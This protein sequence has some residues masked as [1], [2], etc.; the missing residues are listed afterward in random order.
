MCE[1]VVTPET[2][3]QHPDGDLLVGLCQAYS[4]DGTLRSSAQVSPQI[5]NL[6]CVSE[7]GMRVNGR[8]VLLP[9]PLPLTVFTAKDGYL[10]LRQGDS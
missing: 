8:L 9:K 6:L 7:L 1:N 10:N 3:G 5:L 4:I 2:V